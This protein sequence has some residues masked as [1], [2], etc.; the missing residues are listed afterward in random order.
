M[1]KQTLDE[2]VE[3]GSYLPEILRG[4]E[5]QT[6][7]INFIGY[8]Y[9]G[10]MHEENVLNSYSHTLLKRYLFEVCLPIFAKNGWTIQPIRNKKINFLNL[11]D[12]LTDFKNHDSNAEERF[13]VYG[14]V[15]TV[16][17]KIDIYR[18]SLSYLPHFL[19]DFHQMKDVFKVI[20][21][22]MVVPEAQKLIMSEINFRDACIYMVDYV[23]WFFA[24]YG[25]N[26]QYSRKRFEFKCEF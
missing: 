6:N 15:S 11:N 8:F 26:L 22:E 20:H 16:D 19:K 13:N 21:W 24:K 7:F 23:F 25:Y 12:V 1:K 17:P 14:K 5:N 18:K 4:K 10:D 3:S 9:N 2:W